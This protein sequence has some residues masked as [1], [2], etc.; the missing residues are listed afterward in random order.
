VGVYTTPNRWCGGGVGMDI[1]ILS[2]SPCSGILPTLVYT[3]IA[4]IAH[5]GRHV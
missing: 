3:T 2:N 4:T 1:G 5:I